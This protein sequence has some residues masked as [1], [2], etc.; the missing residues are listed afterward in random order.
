MTNPTRRDTVCI[1]N[2]HRPVFNKF[3]VNSNL[4][5]VELI[6]NHLC[7]NTST[8]L[9]KFIKIKPSELN[10]WTPAALCTND[11][12]SYMQ[13]ILVRCRTFCVITNTDLCWL[14]SG[15]QHSIKINK[16]RSMCKWHSF[17]CN[18]TCSGVELYCMIR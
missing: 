18:L 3:C 12:A 2:R 8:L 5:C 4:S 15:S 16:Y 13:F 1:E 17:L 9:I 6:Y 11:T 10:S 7:P 14:S